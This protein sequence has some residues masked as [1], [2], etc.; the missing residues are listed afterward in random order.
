M[1]WLGLSLIWHG[2]VLC[3]VSAQ[4]PVDTRRYAAEIDTWF[5][6]DQVT[7]D[8]CPAPVDH[9]P[10]E[11]SSTDAVADSCHLQLNVACW[12][13]EQS[14]CRKWPVTVNQRPAELRRCRQNFNSWGSVFK[15]WGVKLPRSRCWSY[16]GG[17]VGRVSPLGALKMQIFCTASSEIL[18]SVAF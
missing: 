9:C 7:A 2:C 16:E 18:Q 5:G 1:Y 11:L 13:H 6:L 8:Q 17:K 12:W 3:S 14:R 4:E 10:A 15:C